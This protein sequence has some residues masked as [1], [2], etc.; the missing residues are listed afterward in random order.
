MLQAEVR[1]NIV[2]AVSAAL[3]TDENR[4]EPDYIDDIA[5]QYRAAAIREIWGESS[6]INSIWT[7]QYIAK[8]SADL[9]DDDNFVRFACPSAIS[10]D[11][12]RDGFFYVGSVDG[13]TAYR[14]VISR[15]SF[16]NANI[17]RITKINNRIVKALWSDGYWEIYGA[18]LIK[19]L[20][21]DGIFPKPTD[22][23]SFN[24][25]YDPYPI[26]DNTLVLMK[27]LIKEEMGV[28]AATPPDRISDST[29]KITQ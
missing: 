7:Q 14:K 15:A 25:D 19:E 5:N 10:I 9:Q 13:N 3:N 24:P 2:R 22:I 26:D 21:V 27:A 11:N 1:E 23:P 20:R 17:H 28:M 8:Y 18:P 4:Y 29:D 6:R 12:F 16:A